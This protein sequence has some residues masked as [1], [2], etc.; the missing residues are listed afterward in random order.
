MGRFKFVLFDLDDTLY[1]PSSGLMELFKQRIEHYMV[2]H[3]GWS[4][5]EAE[6]RR[7]E[8]TLTYGSTIGGLH[9]LY[10]ADVADYMEYIHDVDHS[11][12]IKPN[13]ALDGMLGR[14]PQHKAIF[15]NSDRG[16]VM[17]VLAAL[18]V[19]PL[20]FGKIIDFEEAGRCPKPGEEAYARALQIIG[21][22][23]NDCLLVEDS[24]RNLAT[25]KL[26]FGMGTVLVRRSGPVT[27]RAEDVADW[28]ID[29]VLGVEAVLGELRG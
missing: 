1:P 10:G 15:T 21:A 29:D 19:S 8:Y 2:S 14:L 18:Q 6:K 17:R 11:S 26:S 16:H 3:Y 27:G 4:A 23:G 9:A 12:F 22:S 13:P 25:A 28:I 7:T 5:D 24:P 20:H